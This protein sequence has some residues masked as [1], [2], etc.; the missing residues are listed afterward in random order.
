MNL[1]EAFCNRMKSVLGAEYDAF[2]ASYEQPPVHALRVNRLKAREDF[3][4]SYAA[5][6]KEQVPWEETGYY[7]DES[8]EPGKSPLH[9]AG[10]YYIQD[11]S[12][13]AP[14]HA[15]E[16][17]PGERILDLCAAPGGK[18]TQIAAAM[19]GQGLLVANEVN[20]ARAKILA[21]NVERMG[22]SNALVTSEYPD[23]LAG[24]FE[25]FFDR[26]LVDAPC[27]GE[28]M[29]RKSE[30][31]VTEWTEDAP[32]LCADR[33][34]GI[35]D[36]AAKMLTPGGR[37][38][39]STCTFAEV[40]DEGSVERF[41][42]R[43]PEFEVVK[44]ERLWPHKIQG[45][46]HFLA[47]LQHRD[48]NPAEQPAEPLQSGAR[49]YCPHGFQPGKPASA[50]PEWAAFRKEF[51]TDA[52]ETLCP[53]EGKLFLFGEQLYQAAPDMPMVKGLKVYRPGLHLGTIQKGRFEP[54]HAL[55]LAMKP[56]MAKQT[57]ELCSSVEDRAA[58]LPPQKHT[59][60]ADYISGLS[61]RTP[62]AQSR[63]GWCLMLV[64]GYSIGWGKAA[65]GQIKNH[66]PKGL[67]KG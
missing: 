43:H 63:K 2:L 60:A 3:A 11:A 53:A 50:F 59:V 38:V 66:Y 58:L 25:A 28:G 23:K 35:L 10:L 27:S 8:L 65:G 57:I 36:C 31:A 51:L 45:E 37:I 56:E 42:S 64:D 5:L 33:Q 39:Y 18:S 17:R 14:V 48:R 44:E 52:V 16:P 32:Q 9:E 49:A 40:E 54:S 61:V 22:I 29:F 1:P 20:A 34:D 24:L 7:D 41:L 62:E 46:G 47:V 30:I 26:I 13:M 55:A 6:L 4:A 12:A 19:Q 15:L 21:L 67:R